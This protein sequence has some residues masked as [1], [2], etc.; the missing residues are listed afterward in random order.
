MQLLYA[1]ALERLL[2]PIAS[3]AVTRALQPL[4]KQHEDA[5]AA[6]AEVE[7]QQCEE[8]E[9][10]QAH[11]REMLLQ[12][13]EEHQEEGEEEAATAALAAALPL[14]PGDDGGGARPP[15]DCEAAT[16]LFG[17]AALGPGSA[18]G[19]APLSAVA[20]AAAAVPTPILADAAAVAGP[21]SAEQVA[22]LPAGTAAVAPGFVPPLPGSSTE[23]KALLPPP[24]MVPLMATAGS[25]TQLAA[26]LPASAAAAPAAPVQSLP[27][28]TGPGSMA[29]PPLSVA[30]AVAEEVDL[31]SVML[32]FEEG[33]PG[34]QQEQH[35]EQEHAGQ[36]LPPLELDLGAG[37]SQQQQQQQHEGPP[38]PLQSEQQP[39]TG[40]QHMLAEPDPDQ[41]AP[42]AAA[43]VL[44]AGRPGTGF[45]HAP[46]LASGPLLPAAAAVAGGSAAGAGWVVPWAPGFAWPAPGAPIPFL[47]PQPAPGPQPQAAQQP[48]LLP[49][50]TDEQ[51]EQLRGHS[52]ELQ[53]AALL[54]LFCLHAA[55]PPMPSP[56]LRSVG[57]AGAAGPGPDTAALEG[58]GGGGGGGQPSGVGGGGGRVKIYL[59]AEHQQAL[60]GERPGCWDWHQDPPDV[61]ILL[62][63]CPAFCSR[64]SQHLLPPACLCCAGLVPQLARSCPD[65]LAALRQLRAAGALVLGASRR[66][67]ALPAE[68]AGGAERLMPVPGL[69][70]GA[71]VCV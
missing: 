65:A 24:Q 53:A 43:A 33:Q 59:S 4:R 19:P 67:V 13:L 38:P 25:T 42:V 68:A 37:I 50:P 71:R 20:P 63:R 70:H 3:S 2:A 66:V 23:L 34:R 45:G 7:R 1:A 47:L 55:H 27:A 6:A 28:A 8:A 31:E 5:A 40:P 56:G 11:L 16:D 54:A 21:A 64:C 14:F 48:V 51:L 9:R 12:D 30:G 44:A 26:L 22:A 17:T 69:F 62:P 60:L 52:L 29:S 39:G 35:H 15:A 46:L 32:D 41:Q 49:L 36:G 18:P 10:Q 61:C 57:E 58:G